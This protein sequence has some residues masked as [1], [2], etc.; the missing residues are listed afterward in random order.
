MTSRVASQYTPA[1]TVVP[2]RSPAMQYPHGAAHATMPR[3]HAHADRNVPP[4]ISSVN[5]QGSYPP[6]QTG[7]PPS[8]PDPTARTYHQTSMLFGHNAVPGHPHAAPVG[9]VPY[10]GNFPTPVAPA[11]PVLSQRNVTAPDSLKNAFTP[12][13]HLAGMRKQ[14]EPKQTEQVA[15]SKVEDKKETEKESKKNEEL[16]T[17]KDKKIESKLETKSEPKVESKVEPGKAPNSPDIA[18]EQSSLRRNCFL[19]PKPH[20]GLPARPPRHFTEQPVK[21]DHQGHLTGH[22]GDQAAGWQFQKTND[23]HGPTWRRSPPRKNQQPYRHRGFSKSSNTNCL[24]TLRR[25]N[26]WEY[27]PCECLYCDRRNRS[28]FVEMAPPIKMEPSVV[29]EA[30]AELVQEYANVVE[31]RLLAGMEGR[32]SNTFMLE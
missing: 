10:G 27:I 9:Q 13:P 22:S 16:E 32:D 3:V 14:N 11:P 12:P 15:E 28:V 18:E 2:S 21:A 8:L 4:L 24:N 19:P 30:M 26:K 25:G 6:V 23:L 29:H 17:K 7:F 20:G 5:F 31:I 1:G